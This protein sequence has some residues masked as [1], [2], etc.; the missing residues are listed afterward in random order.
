M[1]NGEKFPKSLFVFLSIVTVWLLGLTFFVAKPYLPTPAPA[2]IAFNKTGQPMLGNP[3]ASVEVVVFDEPK[4]PFCKILHENIFSKLKE[5]YIDTNKINYTIYTVSF[6]PNSMPAAKAL[7]CAYHQGGKE[8]P[9]LFYD[10]LSYM[11]ANQP[12]ES[13]DWATTDTLLEM[14]KKANSK[15]DQEKLR[16]CLQT[17]QYDEIVKKNT[18]YGMEVMQPFATPALFINGV[19]IPPASY[20]EISKYIDDKL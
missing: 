11:F 1:S 10:Y 20:E 14:A 16:A 18:A 12:E 5:N 4:C 2:P 9:E 13:T 19:H 15:I 7:M 17:T 3:N 8:N 6:L